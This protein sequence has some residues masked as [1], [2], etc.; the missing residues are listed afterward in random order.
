MSN[1]L[2]AAQTDSGDDLNYAALHLS[3]RGA[4][5]GRK[6][7]EEETEESVYSQVKR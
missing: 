3:G 7:K 4:T 5:A 6:K 2:F 1:E